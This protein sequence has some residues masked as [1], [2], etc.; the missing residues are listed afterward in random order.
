[1]KECFTI[2]D[3][4]K[5]L[6]D[7]YKGRT[8]GLVGTVRSSYDGSIAVNLDCLNNER[9]KYGCYYFKPKQLEF[10]KGE[11]NIMEGNYR[12]AHVKFLEGNNTDTVYHYALYDGTLA[13][14]GDICVVKSAHHGFGLARIVEI[15]PKTSENI[16]RE[17]ICRADFTAYEERVAQRKRSAELMA[18]M[19]KRAAAVQEIMIY[20]QLAAQDPAMAELLKEYEQLKGVKNYECEDV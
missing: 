20:K 10:L 8:V 3:R 16:T 7:N 19:K 17:I 14:E 9:S 2:G 1:M 15:T 12:I 6:A 18:E 4:V 13:W 5:V 11:T